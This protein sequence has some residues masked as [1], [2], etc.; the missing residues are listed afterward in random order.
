MSRVW[1]SN[2]PKQHAEPPPASRAAADLPP[3]PMPRRQ[4]G[5]LELDDATPLWHRV[6]IEVAPH[7]PHQQRRVEMLERQLTLDPALTPPPKATTKGSSSRPAA[8]R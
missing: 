3:G 5:V 7:V 4:F 6:G 2:M 8:V 1:K